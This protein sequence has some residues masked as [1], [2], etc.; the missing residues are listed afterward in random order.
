MPGAPGTVAVHATA[1]RPHENLIII[2][3]PG[4]REH[5][6]RSRP[7]PCGVP[8]ADILVVDD[9]SP[10]GA[11]DLATAAGRSW[12]G[13]TC[14]SA[15]PRG[16]GRGLP[17]GEACTSPKA[18]RSW[19]DGRRPVAPAGAAAGAAGRGR[20]RRHRHRIA[21]RARGPHHQLAVRAHRA[22]TRRQL[23]PRP[24]WGWAAG[25]PPSSGPTRP[26]SWRRSRPAPRRRPATA[27]SWSCPTGPTAW[28]PA[29]WRCPSPS[30]TACGACPRCRGTSSARPCRW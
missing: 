13:S 21:L 29:S 5:R 8:D 27:S 24:C 30:T 11:A 20:G 25:P 28:A 7:G 6:R 14:W 23:P 19:S 2:P 22:L 3:V 16:P 26:T 17:A 4:G 12:A 10:D 15:R 1:G 9:A 18:M